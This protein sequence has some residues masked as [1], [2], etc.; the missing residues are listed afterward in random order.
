MKTR[1][2]HIHFLFVR[3]SDSGKT[4]VWE[5]YATG[6]GDI[7]T[8]LGDVE[9]YVPWRQYC[10]YPIKGTVF[11]RSCLRDIADFLKQMAEA[12]RASL[13]GPLGQLC[14]TCED[15]RPTR[16]YC[17]IGVKQPAKRRCR[18]RKPKEGG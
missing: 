8:H 17:R 12:H 10:F 3:K 13:A 6:K 14:G 11:S 15:G 1:Y 7:H 9:W 2:K 5:C 4:E 16:A 18:Y